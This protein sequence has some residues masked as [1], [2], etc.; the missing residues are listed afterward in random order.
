[1]NRPYRMFAAALSWGLLLVGCSGG[2]D[3]P[4]GNGGG[5]EV[6]NSGGEGGGL[7][8]GGGSEST[9]SDENIGSKAGGNGQE[10]AA[11][12]A[13]ML[14][15][16]GACTPV[17][18]TVK[19]FMS[20]DDSNSMASPVIARELLNSGEAPHKDQIRTHEFLNYYNV[21]YDLPP[22]DSSLLGLHVEMQ[23][24][25]YSDDIVEGQY[26]LQVGIQA[27]E[28]SRVPVVFTFVVDS[29]GSLVG[30]GIE[31]ER[32]ALLAIAKQLSQGDIVNVVTWSTDN[33]TL[34]ENYLATGTELDTQ[35]MID[36]VGKL[37]PGGGS[38]LHAG[39]RKGYELAGQHNDTKKLNRVVLLS[40]GG[41]NLGVIDRETI[42]NFSSDA[43][44]NGI[45]LVG[46]GVG[47]AGGYSDNLMDLVTDAGRGAYVYL[48]SSKE[49]ESVFQDRFDE[50]MNIAASNVRVQVELP[51]YLE[52]K[53]FYGEEYSTDP[54][55]IEPQNLAPGDSMILNQTL[56]MTPT[57]VAC[58][59]DTIT[60]T[61]T[62]EDPVTH[63]PKGS[64]VTSKTL[65]E[66]V[67]PASPQARKAAAVIA[68]AEALKVGD[69]GALKGALANV[70]SAEK[71]LGDSDLQN[72]AA[73]I[74][75]HPSF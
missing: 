6:S 7:G 12:L 24:F 75:L 13:P 66:L 48:D 52:I 9:L 50:V 41:A 30:E 16:L 73:L 2:N 34:L 40:D 70:E 46:I 60:V 29:S 68:Y 64:S 28:V 63:T 58:G 72:I 4:G 27:G 31:R 45:Y 47:P 61:L 14:D 54:E 67:A 32:A 5:D 18:P 38:D 22:K 33:N 71:E 55:F 19:F 51:E 43:N 36:V 62:W 21:H 20:A 69:Q 11:A 37:K 59:L 3:S 8:A 15:G 65:D 26:R 44:A 1:M 39:L 56:F 35:K 23:N 74:Q 10:K 57:T 17:A 42:A 25:Q 49:A 53:D